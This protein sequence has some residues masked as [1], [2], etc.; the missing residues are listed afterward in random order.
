MKN[1]RT[2]KRVWLHAGSR[3]GAKKI[4][5]KIAKRKLPDIIRY[6]SK[7]F[8]RKPKSLERNV[9]FEGEVFFSKN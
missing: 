9:F 7:S 1:T 3:F 5:K 4:N 6:F 2:Y 8:L